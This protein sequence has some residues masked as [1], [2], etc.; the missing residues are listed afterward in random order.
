MRIEISETRSTRDLHA[1]SLVLENPFNSNNLIIRN[2]LY[3]HFF[4]MK[5]YFIKTYHSLASRSYQLGIDYRGRCWT[6]SNNK[7]SPDRDNSRE[8]DGEISNMG[9]RINCQGGLRR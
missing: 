8:L 1:I 7:N 6:T 5:N 9:H 2:K 4:F 3:I